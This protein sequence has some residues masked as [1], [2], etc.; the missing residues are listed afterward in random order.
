MRLSCDSAGAMLLAILAAGCSVLEPTYTAA[1]PG[2]SGRRPVEVEV[3]IEGNAALGTAELRR[4]IEDYLFDLS[5]DPTRESAVYDAAIELE[6]R[7][8][9]AGHPVAKVAYE[10]TPP[11]P[12]QPWPAAVRVVFHV[13]EGPLVT[14]ALTLQGNAAYGRDELLALWSRRRASAFRLGSTTFVE[15]EVRTFVEEL[16]T[17]YRA[18]GR[19][20]AVVVGP[21]IHVDLARGVATVRIGIQEGP[22]HVIRAVEVA[23]AIRAALG[24]DLPALPTGRPYAQ[25]EVRALREA[26]REAL[27][28]RGHPDPRVELVATPAADTAPGWRIEVAGEPGPAATVASVAVAGNEKTLDGIVL[29]KLDLQ[30]G[31]RYDGSKVD[32][33]LQQ[34]YRTGLFRKVDIVEQPAADDPSRLG[35]TVQVEEADSRSLEFLA[36]YGS[37][38]QLRGGLRL[39][40]RNVFGTGR[41]IALDNK[42]SMKGYG[43]E[44]T[45]TDSDFLFTGATLTVSGEYFRREEPS[46]TD[47]AVGGTVALSRQLVEKLTARVGYTYLSRQDPQAFTTLPQDQLVDFVEGKVFFELRHDR[48]DNLLFPTSGHAE[49]LSFERIAPEFGASVDL[50]RLTG[51]ATW[52][53]P[54]LDPV[55]LVLRTEQSA[56]W[57]HEGSSE[58]PL[59]LRWFNGG[60]SSVRSYRESQLGVKD[61]SGQPVGGEYRNIFGAELR[62]PLWRT[63]EGSLFADAGNVGS[64]VQDFSFDEMGYGLGA[65]LRLLLPIGPVRVD[66]AWNPDRKPG[67]E[68]WVVHFSVGYPF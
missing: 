21:D 12:D 8:R 50:D 24:T 1:S 39:E 57:P 9:A 7:C 59:Q 62:F 4:A 41:G 19:L 68:A 34:L 46:F 67:D 61:A 18:R 55:T 35:L 38:E 6:D 58:V 53:V 30:A 52:H 66:A 47:E 11:A 51:R 23:P 20:D 14:V 2:A 17:F 31:D 25:Q 5:R 45:L 28:R 15:A 42:V 33:A 44:L 48:R 3:R 26:V 56:L 13:A 16:R 29:G 37:Y 49:F 54:L 36:G 60:E 22:L 43:S 27:R 64:R 40:D 32:A 65:G 63:L 10:Y